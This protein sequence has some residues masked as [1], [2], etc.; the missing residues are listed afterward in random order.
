MR[1]RTTRGYGIVAAL[2]GIALVNAS[3]DRPAAAQSPHALLGGMGQSP[4][5]MGGFVTGVPGA[6]NAPGFSPLFLPVPGG[7]G[8]GQMTPSQIGAL[9]MMMM[10]GMAGGYGVKTPF[11]MYPGMMAP[12]MMNPGM[13]NPGMMAGGGAPDVQ[14]QQ[15]AKRRRLRAPREPG[16]Q[17][18]ARVAKAKPAAKKRPRQ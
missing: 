16:K 5:A 17:K 14:P 1:I 8:G 4:G 2:C 11:S 10:A 13:M 6:A 15:P 3:V 18:K 12:G 7:M 9:E